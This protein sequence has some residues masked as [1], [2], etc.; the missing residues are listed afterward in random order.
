M[1]GSSG[2]GTHPR[3]SEETVEPPQEQDRVSVWPASEELGGA[4]GPQLG[5]REVQALCTLGS[6]E[7]GHAKMGEGLVCFASPT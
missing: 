7:G 2:V 5:C 6:P 1:G 4:S 3:A